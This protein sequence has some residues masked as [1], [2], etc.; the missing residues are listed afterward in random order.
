MTSFYLI[1]QCNVCGNQYEHR[2]MDELEA[3]DREYGA[4]SVNYD[5]YS[6]TKEIMVTGCCVDCDDE[7]DY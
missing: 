4:V 7:E 6:D 1:K 2:E 3:L 5:Q